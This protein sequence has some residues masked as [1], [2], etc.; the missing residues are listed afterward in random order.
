MPLKYYKPTSPGRRGASAI[1][2]T[3]FSDK[4]PER[5]LTVPLKKHGGRNAQGK[6]TVRHRGGGH[7]RQYRIIDFMQNRHDECAVVCA[8]EYDP[9]RSVAIALVEF[10]DKEKRYIIAPLGLA[11]GN[12]IVSTR[13]KTEATLGNRMPLEYIPTGLSIHN[14][15][16]MAS[17][18]GKM[19]RSAG[20]SAVLMNIEGDYAQVK[21]PS[22][23]VRMF[24]KQ[25]AASIG[26]LS[27]PDHRLVRLGK[28]GRM[29][30]LGRRPRV[31]GKAMNPVDHPHGGGEG[32]NPIGMKFPKT[33]WGKPA[34]GVP[35]RK[36]NKWT[37]RL[38]I[39]K[40]AK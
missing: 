8:I 37:N 14:I 38:I 26:Q 17:Q 12:T 35:T 40:R 13:N 5:M 11:E 22:G 10:P 34:L 23:E 1:P 32:H 33:P 18:G 20:S 36:R 16:L 24:S 31:R 4:Q 29:R 27:N 30:W 19:V 6:I 25:C 39:K 2:H 7:K 15:E 28:A 3:A 21:M 9:N